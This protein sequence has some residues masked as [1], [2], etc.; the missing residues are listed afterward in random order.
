M[1]VGELKKLLENVPD[2]VDILVPGK[3]YSYKEAHCK[4]GNA[5]FTKEM[6]WTKNYEN[7]DERWGTLL[8]VIIVGE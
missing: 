4:I 3:I 6:G 1:K 8:K 5:L 7:P 2:D